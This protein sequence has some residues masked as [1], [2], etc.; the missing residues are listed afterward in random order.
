MTFLDNTLLYLLA[1]ADGETSEEKIANF[2]FISFLSGMSSLLF[3]F[4][5]GR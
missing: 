5:M 1:K 4:Y 2:T 3:A